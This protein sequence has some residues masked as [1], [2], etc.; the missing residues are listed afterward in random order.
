LAVQRQL[1]LESVSADEVQA[2]QRRNLRGCAV[3]FIASIP[4]ALR[5]HVAWV[6]VCLALGLLFIWLSRAKAHSGKASA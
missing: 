4:T 5:V 2:T 6:A 1:L 3:L